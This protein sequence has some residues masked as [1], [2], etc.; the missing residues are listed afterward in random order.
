MKRSEV[1]MLILIAN[2]GGKVDVSKLMK[3]EDTAGKHLKH[4]GALVKL[5]NRGLVLFVGEMNDATGFQQSV[6][7]A[8]ELYEQF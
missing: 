6:I 7:L 2:Y 3:A 4:L 1:K 8:E 5:K